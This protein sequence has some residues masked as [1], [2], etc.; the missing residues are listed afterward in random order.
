LVVTVIAPAA[1]A[2]E[3]LCAGAVV[4]AGA[5]AVCAGVLVLCAGVLAAADPVELLV[6]LLLL[7]QP[8]SKA[9]TIGATATLA[10]FIDPPGPSGLAS[11]SKDPTRC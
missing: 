7:P 1:L 9:R 10:L 5:V 11:W 3:L 8:A 6:V 2:V 4:V